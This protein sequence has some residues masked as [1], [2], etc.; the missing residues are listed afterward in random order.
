MFYTFLNPFK[1]LKQFNKTGLK[2]S[3]KNA[4]LFLEATYTGWCKITRHLWKML[5]LSF[6]SHCL[7]LIF[8]FNVESVF[9]SAKMKEFRAAIV[10][11]RPTK[12]LKHK[13]SCEKIA[14]ISSRSIPIGEI[15]T[16]NGH[17]ALQIGIPWTTRYGVSWNQKHA[18]NRIRMSSLWNAS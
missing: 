8:M 10:E 12:Q 16:A 5:F 13:N 1:L 18:Q 4:V 3:T 7:V 11:H 9:S 15:P 6:Y 2:P 14:P 17:P